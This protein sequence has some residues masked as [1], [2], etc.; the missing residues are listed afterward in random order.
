MNIE[1]LFEK[2][3]TAYFDANEQKTQVL[4]KRRFER[5]VEEL[6][7]QLFV[8]ERQ[9]EM[10]IKE[11]EDLKSRV[12]VDEHE[13]ERFEVLLSESLEALKWMFKNMQ[14]VD[15]NLQSDAFNIPANAIDQLEKHLEIFNKL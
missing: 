1:D 5:A 13:L 9:N 10:L 6:E 14:V 11:C 2:H 3:S 15:S 7:Q 8:E 12:V 4:T